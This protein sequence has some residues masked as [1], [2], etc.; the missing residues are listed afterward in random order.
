MSSMPFCEDLQ[1]LRRY[2][3]GACP[4][5]PLSLSVRA[6]L[7][8]YQRRHPT[9][10]MLEALQSL[11]ERSESGIIDPDPTDAFVAAWD[12]PITNA[13]EAMERYPDPSRS[14]AGERDALQA[15]YGIK[16]GA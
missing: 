9:T 4:T 5:R 1:L 14:P 11:L 15:H 8:L 10:A 6:T 3:P 16:P 7:A 2:L 12:A 13:T